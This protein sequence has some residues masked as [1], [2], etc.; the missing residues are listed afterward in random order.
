MA[1]VT[2]AAPDP[3]SFTFS[4]VVAEETFEL[5]ENSV[6]QAVA[7]TVI[8]AR[9]VVMIRG[10]FKNKR[11]GGLGKQPKRPTTSLMNVYLAGREHPHVIDL[12]SITTPNWRGNNTAD[13][14]GLN[15]A[16]DLM[17]DLIP[18]T[19]QPPPP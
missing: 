16:I 18:V 11:T 4:Y 6:P 15:A 14:A 8:K 10:F 5:V 3:Y 9:H 2:N 13:I 17:R 19:A 1:D 12:Y 7:K